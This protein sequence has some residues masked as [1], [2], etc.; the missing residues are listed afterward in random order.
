M[1]IV[2]ILLL[3]FLLSGQI[4]KNSSNPEDKL[5]NMFFSQALEKPEKIE[6]FM[7]LAEKFK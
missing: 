1:L 3:A 6:G 7:K 2:K 5:M 4:Q